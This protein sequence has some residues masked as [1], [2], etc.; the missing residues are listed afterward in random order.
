[1]EPLEAT[2]IHGTIVQLLMLVNWLDLPDGRDRY[3]AAVA[4]Q[5]LDVSAVVN[6]SDAALEQNRGR[7]GVDLAARVARDQPERL[8]RQSRAR[9]STTRLARFV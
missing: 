1:M 9:A 6:R 2:S 4:R 8:R 5:V 7:I 3:N